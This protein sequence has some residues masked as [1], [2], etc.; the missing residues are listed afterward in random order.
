MEVPND[1]L[2]KLEGYF[3]SEPKYSHEL[4]GEEFYHAKFSVNRLSDS[5]DILNLTISGKLF[6]KETIFKDRYTTVMGQ[7][8]SYN[9]VIGSKN[10]LLLTVFVRELSF[11]LEKS[12]EPNSIIL[13]GFIC[14]EP[15][16]RMTPFGREITDLLIAV[17][18]HFN[19]TDY[20]PIIAWGRNAKYTKSMSIGDKIRIEGRLQSRGYTKN[21]PDGSVEEKVAYEVSSSV[22]HLLASVIDNEDEVIDTFNYNKNNY[23]NNLNIS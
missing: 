4:Y 6:E 23:D 21:Y 12:E 11:P 18:R 17:N 2:V 1:N 20:I 22:V 14:K 5:K 7:I 3:L 8:R 13:T 10:K 9:K 15:N 19:K 16:Y